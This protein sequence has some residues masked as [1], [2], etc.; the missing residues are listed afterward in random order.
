MRAVSQSSG[1][2]VLQTVKAITL[3]L[4]NT[5]WAIGPV[6]HRAE[7]ELWQWLAEHYPAIPENFSRDRAAAVRERVVRQHWHKNHDFRFLR[8]RVLEQMAIESGY[9]VELVE[10]AFAVFDAA[11]NRVTLYPDVVNALE[12][13]A[14]RYRVVALT[15]GNANLTTIGI[16]HLFHDVVTA[17]D[18]GIAK[19][20]PAIFR[21]AVARAGTTAEETLHVGDDPQTDVAGA[22]GAGLKSAWMNRERGRWPGDLQAPDITVHTMTELCEHLE[23]D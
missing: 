13:L 20:A 15:N 23:R 7:D 21:Q 3:D 8:K 18:A 16:R 22:A 2:H 17:V 19:P 9:T 11:R 6:I 10:D 1:L 4:D 12:Q 14:A 5:L